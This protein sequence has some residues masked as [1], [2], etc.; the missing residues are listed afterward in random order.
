L[1]REALLV[2]PHLGETPHGDSGYKT[3]KPSAGNSLKK[4]TS[5]DWGYISG[6]S[7]R[8]LP[9]A[10]RDKLT[11]A[12]KKAENDRKGNKKGQNIPYTAATQ[13]LFADATASAAKKPAKK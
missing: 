8:Y 10:I 7:G 3:P 5:E 4:W 11:P 1:E 2:T 13:K 6:T 9:K 12:Q